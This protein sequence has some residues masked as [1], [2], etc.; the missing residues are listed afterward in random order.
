MKWVLD[1]G[2]RII[3]HPK[4]EGT[5]KTHQNPTPIMYMDGNILKFF[6]Y[7]DRIQIF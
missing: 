3:E 4:L 1:G 7:K 5:H 6:I 2:Y